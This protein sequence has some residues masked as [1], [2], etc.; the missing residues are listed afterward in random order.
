MVAVKIVAPLSLLI[1][2]IPVVIF[3]SRLLLANVFLNNKAFLRPNPPSIARL[4]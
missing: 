1:L 4:R 2:A 3:M